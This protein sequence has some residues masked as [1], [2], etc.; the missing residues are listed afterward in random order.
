MAS[1]SSFSSADLVL[2]TGANGHVASHVVDQLWGSPTG[3]RVR[4]TVRSPNALEK[5][6]GLYPHHVKSGRLQVVRVLDMTAKGAF[7]QAVQGRLHC[8]SSDEKKFDH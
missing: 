1:E 4:A 8:P 2:V 7:D 5:V 3:I 6:E